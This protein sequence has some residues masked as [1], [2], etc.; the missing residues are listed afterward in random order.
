VARLLTASY[1]NV[2]L[3]WV[4]SS[5]LVTDRFTAVECQTKKPFRLRFTLIGVLGGFRD[6][7]ALPTPR[8]GVKLQGVSASPDGKRF[9]FIVLDYGPKTCDGHA[10]DFETQLYTIRADGTER[11]LIARET[12]IIDSDWSDDG[13]WLAYLVWNNDGCE[14]DVVSAD[15]SQKR[16]LLRDVWCDGQLAWQP[17]AR[18]IAFAG[19]DQLDLVDVNNGRVRTLVPWTVSFPSPKSFSQDGRW[20]AVITDA[21]A[22]ANTLV[23]IDL[24]ALPEGTQSSYEVRRDGRRGSVDDGDLVF[25]GN[26]AATEISYPR[27]REYHNDH[28]TTLLDG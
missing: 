9:S 8:R 26:S 16:R 2:P 18:M 1:R 25:V 21:D 11:R 13:Q 5:S 15:G 19:E 20:L 4:D 7:D 10:G 14:V 28:S 12:A 6:I 23:R 17:H 22:D 24:L 27:S 3:A